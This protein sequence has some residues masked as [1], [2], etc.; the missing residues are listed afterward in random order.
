MVRD[1]IALIQYQSTNEENAMPIPF[2]FFSN[3][4]SSK[5]LLRI[6]TP[7]TDQYRCDW[8]MPKE[9]TTSCTSHTL[10]LTAQ[11]MLPQ[12]SAKANIEHSSPH[13][14][15]LPS[16]CCLASTTVA[17]GERTGCQSL[18]LS[19]VNYEWKEITAGVNRTAPVTFSWSIECILSPLT[20]TCSH[21]LSDRGHRLLKHPRTGFLVINDR[22]TP[23]RSKSTLFS[24]RCMD[25]YCTGCPKSRFNLNL[26]EKICN[27]MSAKV[28]M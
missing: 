12:T 11:T 20:C 9:R 16:F 21:A 18:S 19:V 24:S 4:Y 13:S 17:H 7:A 25:C 2:A 22:W 10:M 27:I 5:F 1:V 8:H 6:P 28:S 23:D 3:K 14:P 15:T 26:I